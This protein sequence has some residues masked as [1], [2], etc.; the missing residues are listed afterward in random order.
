MRTAFATAP[1]GHP[2]GASRASQGRIATTIAVGGMTM[3]F[4]TLLAARASLKGRTDT[5]IGPDNLSTVLA[6]ANTCLLV[7]SSLTF[8]RSISIYRNGVQIQALGPLAWS[9]ALASIFLTLQF[10]VWQRLKL[11]G[12]L[13]PTNTASALL[14][15]LTGLHA[16]HLLVA[17]ALAFWIWMVMAGNKHPPRFVDWAGNTELFWHALTALWIVLFIGLFLFP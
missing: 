13:D 7:I 8:R 15:A 2:S 1:L 9:L 5:W 4:L 17:V 6:T 12:L 14:L 11:A 16:A 3:L 10:S